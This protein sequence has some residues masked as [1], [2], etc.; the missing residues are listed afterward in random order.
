MSQT[1]ADTGNVQTNPVQ[2]ALHKQ[3]QLTQSHTQQLQAASVAVQDLRAQVQPLQVSVE[4]LINQQSE[5]A[6]QQAAILLQLQTLTAA[7]TQ[8]PQAQPAPPIA[9]EPA[10]VIP[11]PVNPAVLI[12]AS[13]EPCISS[14][15]PFDGNFETCATFVMQCELVF[16]HQPSMFTTDAARVAYLTNLLTGRAAQWATASWSMGA[17]FC[18]SYRDFVAELQKVFHHPA[19]G[20]DPGTRLSSIRQGSGSVSEYSVEFRLAA[21]ESGWNDQSLRVTFRRGLSDAVKDQ[22]AT[23]EEP[24]SLDGLINLAIRIDG[25]LQERR[26]E[27][28]Q[29]GSSSSPHPPNPLD[30]YP[31]FPASP[32]VGPRSTPPTATGE[33]PMQLGRTRLSPAEREARFKAG[34]CL[35]CGQKGHLICNCPTRPKE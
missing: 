2:A 30:R 33:E 9:V 10:P 23:R 12:P 18:H 1:P 21:V 5:L 25:R 4:A 7:L 8:L 16:L 34:L 6:S 27:R 32:T 19:G 15:R 29:R 20:R 31:A 13:R 26:R 11:P 28:T 24:T 22:L 3:I 14:P 35:Y 17:S